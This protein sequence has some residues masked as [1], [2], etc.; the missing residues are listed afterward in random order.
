MHNSIANIIY[1]I[2][3]MLMIKQISHKTKIALPILI[4]ISGVFIG[5]CSHSTLIT[6]EPDLVFLLFLP[7]LL[8]E[9]TQ[10]ISLHDIKKWRMPILSLSIGLVIF[11]IFCVAAITQVIIPNFTW[12]LGFLI[13]AIVAPPDSIAATSILRQVGITGSVATILEGESLVNDAAALIAYK[14]ALLAVM[15]GVFN[16]QHMAFDF[17]LV[18]IGGIVIG[19]LLGVVIKE[20]LR[21][22]QDPIII[23][24]LTLVTPIAVYLIAE[25]LEVSGVLAVVSYGLYYAWNKIA[26]T[27]FKSRL[28]SKELWDIISFILN[29]SVFILIGIQIPSIIRSIT[30]HELQTILVHGLI[31][32]LVLII[33]RFAWIYVLSSVSRQ[34]R[35]KLFP[36]NDFDDNFKLNV[37]LISWSGMRGVVTLATA[38]ALPENLPNGAVFPFRN[39]ILLIA[40]IVILFSLLLHGF[41]LPL[42]A[43]K[44]NN[45]LASLDSEKINSIFG[46]LFAKTESF[47]DNVK[48]DYDPQIIAKIRQDI[49]SF[50]ISVDDSIFVN[51]QLI[52][53]NLRTI[54]IQQQDVLYSWYTSN[55]YSLAKIKQ[56][57]DNLDHVAQ[58]IEI[59]YQHFEKIKKFYN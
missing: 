29:G 42:L 51:A 31:I 58:M 39:E 3:L 47:L 12:A 16:T 15:F 14:S 8:Y 45:N 33:T 23:N 48:D 10:E 34:L 43:K 54:V 24:S 9:A 35:H 26:F 30:N 11:T 17:A 57:Q 18:F 50:N 32:C 22:T 44:I 4:L 28:Q 25:T 7:P 53:L 2:L 1:I 55:R 38:L 46:E 37:M 5:I 13:G 52:E 6:L 49:E 36:N 27:T 41:T 56:I 40:F 59:R 19:L 20:L 21:R